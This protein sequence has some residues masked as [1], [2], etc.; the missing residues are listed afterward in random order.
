[1]TNK[2]EWKNQITLFISA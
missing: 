2:A 1:M